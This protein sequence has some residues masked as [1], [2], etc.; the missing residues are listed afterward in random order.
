MKTQYLIAALALFAACVPCAHAVEG[1]LG[2]PVSG[3]TIN[4]FAGVV[5]PDPGFVFAIGPILT[6]S[7]KFGD[8]QLDPNARWIHEFEVENRFDGDVFSLSASYKF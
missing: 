8:S 5:P 7:K 6:Y 2:R 3:M 4:P 1:A